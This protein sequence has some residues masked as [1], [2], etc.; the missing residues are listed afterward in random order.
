M[1]AVQVQHFS[2][3]ARDFLK[4]MESLVR[5]DIYV[6][7]DQIL[8][9]KYS[10]ALLSIHCAIS[11]SDALRAGLGCTDVS[12]DDHR[13]AAMDLRLRLTDRKYENL[14]GADRLGK[15]L[16]KKNSIAYAS[17]ATRENE[18]EDIVKHAERFTKWAEETGRRLNIEGW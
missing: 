4:G 7:N 14:K 15:L 13:N 17:E 16:S 3:R 12:S 10:T 9:F 5:E 1:I 8:N 6:L 2:G 11:Y 18:I